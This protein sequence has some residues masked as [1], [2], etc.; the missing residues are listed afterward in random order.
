MISCKVQLGSLEVGLCVFLVQVDAD[1]EVIKGCL[2]T[3]ESLLGQCS[4]EKVL[5]NILLRLADCFND[6]LQSVIRLS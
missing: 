6:V 1:I 5:C 4:E 3:V 2:V